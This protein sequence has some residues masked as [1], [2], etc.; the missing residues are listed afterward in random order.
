MVANL[1][2]LVIETLETGVQE[3]TTEYTIKLVISSYR[4]VHPKFQIQG[5]DSISI[6][7]IESR[8]RKNMKY[9]EY[10]QTKRLIREMCH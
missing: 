8:I 9:Y 10:L 3:L 5:Y 1:P 7:T 2:S 6:W 4:Y